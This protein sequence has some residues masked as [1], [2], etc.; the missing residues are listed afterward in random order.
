MSMTNTNLIGK[1]K[2][3]IRTLRTIQTIAPSAIIAGGYHRDIFTGVQFHDVDI[4]VEMDSALLNPN[5]ETT[6]ISALRLKVDDLRSADSIRIMGSGEVD[7]RIASDNDIVTVFAMVK[8]ETKYNII[9]VD[10]DP[11]E[12]IENSFDFNICKTW[13]DGKRIHFSKEFMADIENKTITFC[14]R[15]MSLNEFTHS[16]DSHLQKLKYKYPDHKVIIPEMLRKVHN[17]YI[18][19]N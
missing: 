12:H 18:K 5:V 11:I 6:W 4:F 15:K 19:N 1:T 13:C 8:G 3:P 9:V 17:Q 2:D 7:Y 10:C 14:E 16:M